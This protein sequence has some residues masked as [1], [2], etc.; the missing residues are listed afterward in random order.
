[1]IPCP[2]D[3]AVTERGA[4]WSHTGAPGGAYALQ[5]HRLNCRRVGQPPNVP[6][7]AGGC[8]WVTIGSVLRWMTP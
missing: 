6:P 4:K 3:S 5:G 8:A 2:D 7:A 1:M